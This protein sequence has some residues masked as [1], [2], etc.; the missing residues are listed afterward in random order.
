MN[1]LKGLES[2]TSLEQ[3]PHMPVAEVL[4]M[5]EDISQASSVLQDD[6]VAGISLNT[7]ILAVMKS[8][9]S[10]EQLRRMSIAEVLTMDEDISHSIIQ[11][12]SVPHHDRVAGTSLNIMLS[13]VPF[14]EVTSMDAKHNS[15]Q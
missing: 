7:N 10:L 15:I 8:T 3:L 14:A 6:C 11:T 12:S 5:D 4:F 9:T 13:H 1:M 2:T